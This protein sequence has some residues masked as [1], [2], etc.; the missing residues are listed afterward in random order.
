VTVFVQI[1]APDRVVLLVRAEGAGATG[2]LRLEVR[3][4]ESA[5]GRTYAAWRAAG[6]GPVAGESADP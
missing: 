2:D 6:P 1:P 5:L 3:P 4:G